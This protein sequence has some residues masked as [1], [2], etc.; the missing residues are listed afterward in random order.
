[1]VKDRS[2]NRIKVEAQ[3]E[4]VQESLKS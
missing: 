2:D 3:N 4:S 1:V